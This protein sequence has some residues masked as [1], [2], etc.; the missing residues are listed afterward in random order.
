MLLG[1]LWGILEPVC[2]RKCA[3][4][5]LFPF[6]S[7]TFSA[8]HFNFI[9]MISA[10]SDTPSTFFP[11]EKKE[12]TFISYCIPGRIKMY[13]LQPLSLGLTMK[14]KAVLH[15]GFCTQ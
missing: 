5:S 11:C 10:F 9:Q 13:L 1:Y 15:S 4:L 2:S 7:L 12:G 6:L 8:T 3:L 14:P